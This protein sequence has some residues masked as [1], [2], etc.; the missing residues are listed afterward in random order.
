MWRGSESDSWKDQCTSIDHRRLP[1]DE[2]L[3][4]GR[5]AELAN[6]EIE[7][8]VETGGRVA[9][10]YSRGVDGLGHRLLDGVYW[11]QGQVGHWTWESEEQG[12]R[13]SQGKQGQVLENTLQAEG[14]HLY[15][16]G[17]SQ[18]M[19]WKV[20]EVFRHLGELLIL[21]PGQE[22]QRQSGEFGG[23]GQQAQLQRELSELRVIGTGR[24]DGDSERV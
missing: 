11:G 17:Q 6:S 22:Y 7:G 13:H 24:G 20:C 23:G 12:R 18:I 3:F 16:T 21:Q 1:I 15:R 14:P 8:E 5:A 4:T 19:Y 2:R 9:E 10:H